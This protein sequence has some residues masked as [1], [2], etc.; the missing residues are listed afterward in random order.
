VHRASRPL[1]PEAVSPLTVNRLSVYLRSLRLLEEQG[2]TRISSQQLAR[3]FHLSP[4]QIRKDLAQFGEFGVRGMGYDVARLARHLSTLLQLD[5]RHG[6]L[7]V[8]MGNLGTALARFPPFNTG[9]FEVVAGFDTDPAK[10]GRQVGTTRVHA[11]AE[12]PSVVAGSGARI[13]ILA[14]PG[15]GAPAAYR[16]VADAGIVSVLNFAPV[17]LAPIEGCRVKN[18]DLRIHLEELAFFLASEIAP[19]DADSSRV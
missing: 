10:I 1:H 8:G 16:E 19:G 7:I 11:M 3:Q 15:S 4:T 12:M 14:V 6:L 5:R 18:V 13:A 9:S 17:T 2:V